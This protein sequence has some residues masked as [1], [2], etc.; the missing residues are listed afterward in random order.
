MRADEATLRWDATCGYQVDDD[1]SRATDIQG[2]TGQGTD[3]QHTDTEIIPSERGAAGRKLLNIGMRRDPM[4]VGHGAGAAKDDSGQRNGVEGS[5]HQPR[6]GGWGVEQASTRRYQVDD[7]ASLATDIHGTAARPI[8]KNECKRMTEM[9]TFS[10]LKWW[11]CRYAATQHL[12]VI[13]GRA[14]IAWEC[15]GHG[16]TMTHYGPPWS[17]LGETTPHSGHI[18]NVREV[19]RRTCATGQSLLNPMIETSINLMG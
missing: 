4:A 7:D 13:Q 1:A 11:E 10:A 9:A 5:R 19:G 17:K 2:T 3:T 12:Y 15:T 16:R 8:W 6:W 18:S 14:L